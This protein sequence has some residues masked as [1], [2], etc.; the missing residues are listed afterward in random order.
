MEE[1]ILLRINNTTMIIFK[2]EKYEKGM[3]VWGA[4]GAAIGALIGVAF[5]SV[6]LITAFGFAI[7]AT[8]KAI[9]CKVLKQS[10]N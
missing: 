1:A 6:S 4:I 8:A 5:G 7:G 2:N 10:K 9:N 3:V